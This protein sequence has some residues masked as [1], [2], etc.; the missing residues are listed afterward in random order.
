M[1]TDKAAD[2]PESGALVASL[3]SKIANQDKELH[4]LRAQLSTLSTQHEHEVRISTP[5]H[6]FL[7][8]THHSSFSPDSEKPSN[9][10]FH[11]SLP[12][13]R[14]PKRSKKKSK[15]NMR[16]SSSTLTRCLRSE[17]LRKRGCGSLEKR[18]RKMRWM[19]KMRME[20]S[21]EESEAMGE[22]E[23]EEGRK[24]IVLE[25]VCSCAISYGYILNL[26]FSNLNKWED[27][28]AWVKHRCLSGLLLS[29][30]IKS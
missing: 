1:Y 8:T 26:L 20:R 12:N 25:C 3:K 4:D 28:R 14:Q 16:T 22:G 11:D 23:R 29:L 17:K 2:N 7:D 6:A 13:S 19:W 27:H 24:E 30:A 15:R 18:C 5:L 9:Q 10:P 21:D